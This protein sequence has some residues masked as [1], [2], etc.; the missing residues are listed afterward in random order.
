LH[1]SVTAGA[2]FNLIGFRAELLFTVLL[3]IL[4]LRAARLPG[5]PFANLLFAPCALL[6]SAAGLA[7]PQ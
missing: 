7:I 2:H 4:T 1:G 6:W 3:L 5:A